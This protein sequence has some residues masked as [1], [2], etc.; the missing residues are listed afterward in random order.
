MSLATTAYLD[1]FDWMT[2]AV[3]GGL[4]AIGLIIFGLSKGIQL[5]LQFDGR[6]KTAVDSVIII[7]VTALTLGFGF[8]MRDVCGL[9]IAMEHDTMVSCLVALPPVSKNIVGQLIGVAAL[10]GQA[11]GI[12]RLIKWWRFKPVT[13]HTDS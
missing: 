8:L 10:T 6:K 9:M 12:Y 11:Y 13:I 2:W 1:P 5:L 4:V 3:L 7:L